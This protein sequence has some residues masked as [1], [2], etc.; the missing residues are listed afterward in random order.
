MISQGQNHL[1][2]SRNPQENNNRTLS[3][4][5]NIMINKYTYLPHQWNAQQKRTE[6]ILNRKHSTMASLLSLDFG[7]ITP[8]SVQLNATTD[9]TVRDIRKTVDGQFEN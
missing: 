9:R 6:L 5:G 4:R 1:H 8:P 3:E 7:M 2:Q